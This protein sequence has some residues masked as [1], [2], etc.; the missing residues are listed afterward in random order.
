[1]PHAQF[2]SESG[3]KGTTIFRITKT[4]PR[5]TSSFNKYL[6]L[7]LTFIN[8]TWHYTLLINIKE[9]RKSDDCNATPRETTE[10]RVT[11][12]GGIKIKQKNK[13]M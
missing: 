2:L 4:F 7:S 6:K 11:E 8:E 12:Y 5:K 10:V 9:I 1:M 13:R 3:C